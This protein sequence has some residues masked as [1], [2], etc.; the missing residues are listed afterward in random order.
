MVTLI[1]L[2]PPSLIVVMQSDMCN[3]HQY[4]LI[5]KYP[6]HDDNM[7]HWNTT[8]GPEGWDGAPPVIVEAACSCRGWTSHKGNV[9]RQFFGVLTICLCCS[10]VQGEERICRGAMAGECEEGLADPNPSLV[11]MCCPLR[12]NRRAV[13]TEVCGDVWAAAQRPRKAKSHHTHQCAYP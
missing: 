13:T 6:C 2:L 11:W 7:V 8:R 4:S 1:S 12:S 9:Q 10:H 5:P 3:W